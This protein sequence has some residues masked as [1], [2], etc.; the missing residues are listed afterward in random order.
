MLTEPL[1][2]NHKLRQIY[3]SP[4]VDVE[5]P[6]SEVNELR[7]QLQHHAKSA[8]L[9]Y[10]RKAQAS[11]RKSGSSSKDPAQERP[12]NIVSRGLSLQQQHSRL[13]RISIGYRHML[14]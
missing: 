3:G 13:D 9:D 5:K 2:V 4:M 7:V 12:V 11:K 8:F 6:S 10:L 1:V 14:G